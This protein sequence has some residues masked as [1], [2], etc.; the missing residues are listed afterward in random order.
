MTFTPG[1]FRHT[2]LTNFINLVQ[3]GNYVVLDT[4]TTGLKRGEICQIAIIDSDG[5]PLLNTLVRTVNPIPTDASRIHHIYDSDVKEAPRWSDVQ[6]LVVDIITHQNVI[7]Y[8]AQYDRKMLHQSDEANGLDRTDYK[9]FSAWWCAMEAFAV[10]YGDWNSYH[11]SYRWQPLYRA[12]QHY[13]L[14]FRDAH[15]ALGDCL[16]TL[17]VIKRMRLLEKQ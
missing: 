8:N 7:V 16:A 14:Q 15:S 17:Q 4:E 2:S 11:R 10:I 1:D 5:N 12:A 13:G 6:P 9:Q 3:S